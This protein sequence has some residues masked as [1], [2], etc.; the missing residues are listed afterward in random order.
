MGSRSAY[1]NN[2]QWAGFKDFVEVSDGSFGIPETGTWN[3]DASRT[4][5][6]ISLSRTLDN[7]YWNTFCIPFSLSEEQITETF[8]TGTKITEYTG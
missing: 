6:E 5:L 3:G 7:S 8:G 1:L 2:T 4:Y